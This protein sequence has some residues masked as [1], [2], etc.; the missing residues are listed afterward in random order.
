MTKLPL[1]PLAWAEPDRRRLYRAVV[2]LSDCRLTPR[3]LSVARHELLVD[4]EVFDDPR[5]GVGQWI[6]PDEQ[7]GLRGLGEE[8]HALDLADAACAAD[9]DRWTEVRRVAATLRVQLERHGARP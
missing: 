8:L 7:D 9:L 2:I 5:Q 6:C 1:H 4:L 3:R